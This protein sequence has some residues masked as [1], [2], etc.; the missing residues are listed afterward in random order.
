MSTRRALVAILAAAA[1][2]R[3]PRR[4]STLPIPSRPATEGSGGGSPATPLAVAMSTGF[5][6]ATET[7]ATTCPSSSARGSSNSPGSGARSG[8]VSTPARIST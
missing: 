4:P 3:L 7:S 8:S 5:T 1:V 6:P 2:L